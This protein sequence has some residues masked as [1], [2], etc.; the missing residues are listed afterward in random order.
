MIRKKER[1][2]SRR[3]GRTRRSSIR[4]IGRRETSLHFSEIVLKDSHILESIEWLR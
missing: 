2:P 4:N 1:L 3:L